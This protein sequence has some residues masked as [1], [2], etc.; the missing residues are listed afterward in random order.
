MKK[1]GAAKLL[2]LFRLLN[3]E[4]GFASLGSSVAF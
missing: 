2:A 3:L 4:M 1:T